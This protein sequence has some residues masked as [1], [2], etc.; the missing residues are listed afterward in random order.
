MKKHLLA[1]TALAISLSANAQKVDIKPTLQKGLTAT[2]ETEMQVTTTAPQSGSHEAN[3]KYTVNYNVLDVNSD[4][5][6]I[7]MRIS[8]V[9]VPKEAEAEGSEM[10]SALKDMDVKFSTSPSGKLYN[11]LNYNDVRQKVVAMMREMV[12]KQFDSNP[13]LAQAT[14]KEAL[15]SVVE[16]QISPEYLKEQIK[17]NDVFSLFG[18][19]LTTGE[20]EQSEQKGIKLSTTYTMGNVFGI[21]TVAGS[22]KSVMTKDDIKNAFFTQLE[23]SGLAKEQVE[24][25]KS[26]WGMIEASGMAKMEIAGTDTYHFGA[27]LWPTDITSSSESS[28]F[29][30]TV[31]TSTKTKLTSHSW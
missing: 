12:D 20:T 8:D 7:N 23:E 13:A 29:G 21:V 17:Q 10:I 14:T 6:I 27:N 22:T 5:A 16:K 11:I 3:T 18:R 19:T 26:Q 4:S 31:N 9:V 24:Q 2:Y 25:A 15:Y 30:A 28:I 1:I